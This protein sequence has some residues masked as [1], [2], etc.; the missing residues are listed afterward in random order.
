MVT[1]SEILTKRTS[2]AFHS[3]PQSS[4]ISMHLKNLVGHLTFKMSN[5]PCLTGLF[6]LLERWCQLKGHWTFE[7][8]YIY[9]INC[10]K[11]GWKLDWKKKKK[12]LKLTP[13][14]AQIYKECF[15]VAI[16]VKYQHLKSW[17]PKKSS[18]STS[19]YILS[20]I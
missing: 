11:N 17:V 7:Y 12:R 13:I 3:L 9:R 16:V 14:I 4:K 6:T 19:F 1:S 20:P 2:K 8:I 10:Q 15:L 5:C 18:A